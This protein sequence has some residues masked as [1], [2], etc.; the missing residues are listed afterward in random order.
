MKSFNNE[1]VPE[2]NRRRELSSSG[3]DFE[4]RVQ[5]VLGENTGLR[6]AEMGRDAH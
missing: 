5:E 6:G 1:T 3:G 4:I 2:L